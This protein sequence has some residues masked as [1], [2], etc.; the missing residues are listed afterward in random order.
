GRL[1][2]DSLATRQAFEKWVTEY[3]VIHLATHA[4]ADDT[5]PANSYITFFG[6]NPDSA[7]LYE[8][9]IYQLDLS[10]TRLAILSAC[11]TGTGKLENSEGIISL[12]RA[13]TY[14][15]CHSVITSL[16]KANDEATAYISTRLHHYLGNGYRADE[17][18]Q[19]AKS[20]YLDNDD[21]ESRFKKPSYWATLVLTGD[22]AAITQRTNWWIP[23]GLVLIM[24]IAVLAWLL[25]RTRRVF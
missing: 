24:L 2:K 18:L 12:S 11:E 20:E 7:R 22:P 23:V 14:A 13:F 5:L 16:W 1:L 3:P 17:A 10:G 4:R 21:I 8:P 25:K 6:E 19:L 9:G 15:G